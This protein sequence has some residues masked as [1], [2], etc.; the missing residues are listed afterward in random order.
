VLHDRGWCLY[1][2][3]L[4]LSVV[5]SAAHLTCA[6]LALHAKASIDLVIA[7]PFDEGAAQV[8]RLLQ[9]DEDELTGV[10]GIG[11]KAYTEFGQDAG[12][13]TLLTIEDFPDAFKPAG[14]AL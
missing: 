5:S 10:S 14:G 4:I 13:D 2:C 8:A 9:R 11:A 12:E 1:S 7:E 6:L 3:T